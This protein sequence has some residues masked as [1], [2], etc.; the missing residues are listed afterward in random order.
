MVTVQRKSY[1]GEIKTFEFYPATYNFKIIN[2]YYKKRIVFID[3]ETT[4]LE[5]DDRI[6]E[7]GLVEMYENNI[8]GREFHSFFNPHKLSTNSAFSVHGLSEKFLSD[9][10]DFSSKYQ[11]IL[12]FIEDAILVGHNI[13]FDLRFLDQELKRIDSN[14]I[15][16]WKSVCTM[17]MA[18]PLYAVRPKLDQLI[19][20]YL[21]GKERNIHTAIDDARLVAMIYPKL[22]KELINCGDKIQLLIEPL[23]LRLFSN[24]PYLEKSYRVL[25]DVLN[26]TCIVD[27]ILNSVIRHPWSVK[28]MEEHEITKEMAVSIATYEFENIFNYLPNKYQTPE[29]CWM[30]LKRFPDNIGLIEKQTEEMC[31]FAVSKS[32][33]AISGVKNQTPELCLMA[34]EI[35]PKSIRYINNQT[36]EIC[37]I[38]LQADGNNLKYINNQTKELCELAVS[39]NPKSLRYIKDKSLKSEIK[40]KIF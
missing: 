27:A 32:S 17:N 2:P 13:E 14:F 4:G 12:E 24:T 10:P 7:I 37:R 3:C 30:T 18:I 25:G 21:I 9:K 35:N 31:R 6:I 23:K 39:V 26:I 8:T 11:E 28:Y 19:E 34:V 33:R 5:E 36:E 15:S 20:R 40:R 1:N 38:A 22:C 16:S 29:I